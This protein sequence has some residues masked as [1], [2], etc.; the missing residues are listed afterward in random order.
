MRTDNKG[1]AQKKRVAL[2]TGGSRNLGRAMAL[3]LAQDGCHVV[4]N[5]R[6]SRKSAESLVSRIESLGGSAMALEGDISQPLSAESLVRQTLQACK[7]LDICI[8]NV[9]DFAVQDVLSQDVDTWHSLVHSNL[10]TAFYTARAA[11]PSLMI[12]AR[13]NSRVGARLIF[14]GV[15]SAERPRPHPNTAPYAAAKAG[16]LVL[17]KTYAWRLAK[18]GVTV[19]MVSPGLTATARL[20]GPEKERLLAKVPAGRFG[21]PDEVAAAVSYLCSPE[22]AYVTGCNILVAGGSYL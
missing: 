6:S 17:M 14:L 7:R 19:N 21:K 1:G 22:A 12:A 16:L 20:K 18:S 4:V 13:K 8:C 9:G 5:Y 11:I 3:R 10:H 15:A 2:I